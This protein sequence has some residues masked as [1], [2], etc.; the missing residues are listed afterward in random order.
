M[1]DHG[2]QE[3]RE[4]IRWERESENFVGLMDD[5]V[6]CSWRLGSRGNKPER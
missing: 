3:G 6:C 1:F 5:R 2:I 4:N